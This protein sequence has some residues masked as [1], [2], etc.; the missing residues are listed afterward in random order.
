MLSIRFL[1]SVVLAGV[2]LL[3]PLAA[4]GQTRA[5]GANFKVLAAE[6]DAARDTDRLDD[7][8]PLY[9]RALALHPSWA[10]GW[11]SLATIYY[12]RDTFDK[13]AAA[14]Q[15]AVALQP[16]NG[17]ALA[18]LGLCEFE[19]GRD[20]LALRHIQAGKNLGLQKNQELWQVVLF[21]EGILLQRSGKFQSAQDTLEQL[22]ERAGPSDAVANILGMTLLLRTSRVL[23]APGSAEGNV[24]LQVGRAE[25]L[26]GQKK[27]DEARPV[28][29]AV[30]QNNPNFPN[31]HYAYGLFLLELRDIPAAIDQLKLEIANAP[32]NTLARLRIAAA[33]YKQDS[34]AGIPFAEEAVKI[35]PEQPFAHLL[36]G[37][38]RLDVDDYQGAIPEL[39]AAKKGLPREPKIYAALGSAYSRAGRREDAVKAR[40]TFARLSEDEKKKTAANER[41]DA[42]SAGSQLPVL[43]LP[44]SPQ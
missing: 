30:V 43:D 1:F 14:F 16:Q 17:T 5:P 44:A 15:K 29:D 41:P 22:C 18:M 23:P 34:A 3:R 31:L 37:L 24:T 42:G 2:L 33:E 39:E 7:A 36:L 28:F 27:Y 35:A 32:S 40:T 8:I 20:Q 25:C 11:W 6:A 19:L 12:D 13:A 10:E 4:P 9:R 21:H 38:L 26:A